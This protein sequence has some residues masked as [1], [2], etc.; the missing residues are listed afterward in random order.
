MSFDETGTE[1][2]PGRD[3]AK[4]A[5]TAVCST[6][7]ERLAQNILNH[8]VW[9][10]IA[11]GADDE[12]TLRANRSSF[13]RIS[14]RP[15]TLVGVACRTPSTSILGR[16]ATAPIGIAPMAYHRLVHP[17]GELATARAASAEGLPLAISVFSSISLEEIASVSRG[18]LWFQTYHFRERSL[19][20]E[21]VQRAEAAGYLALVLT[22]D[23]PLMG[24]R[25]RD[26]RNGFVIPPHVTAANLDTR[27]HGLHDLPAGGSAVAQ[28]TEE[29]VD[30]DMRWEDLHWYR[31]ITSLPL[32]VKGILTGE[33]AV[34][35]AAM[36]ADAVIV[37]N[38]GGRQL[39]GAIAALDALPE[40]VDAVAGRCEVFMDGGIRRGTDVLK[41]LALG[42]NAVLI[43]RP[44]LW[45]LAVG[46][47]DVVRDVLRLFKTELDLAMA[48]CGCRTVTEIR[49]DLI[50]SPTAA[51][52]DVMRIPNWLS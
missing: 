9:D 24:H 49:T 36:G 13:Q 47:E 46:G 15:R 28:V 30:P 18:P 16:Q 26:I 42:A 14:L 32:I 23:T 35:A 12:I 39:D 7:Y 34:R 43:G 8:A 31:S 6:D 10:F 3:G 37:S 2:V 33:D 25:E 45:G 22:V 17:A 51:E 48:L 41:A 38:H 50:R 44:I 11:G 52:T 1:D 19:T 29:L 4:F 5:G 40:V 21:L 27:S 20:A